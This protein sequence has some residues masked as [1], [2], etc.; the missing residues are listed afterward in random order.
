MFILFCLE[1][2]FRSIDHHQAIF[3]TKL[4]IRCL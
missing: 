2:V 3:F 1:N 4:R